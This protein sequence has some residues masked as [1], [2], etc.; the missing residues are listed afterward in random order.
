MTSDINSQFPTN[1]ESLFLYSIC[2]LFCLGS[3]ALLPFLKTDVSVHSSALVRPASEIN[4]LR[5]LS[6][7]RIKESHVFENKKV[8]EGEV[9]YIIESETLAEQ[10]KYNL[11]KIN[12]NVSFIR[13]VRNLIGTVNEDASHLAVSVS[14]ELYKQGYSA[15][16]QKLSEAQSR[17]TKAKKDYDR[18][19]KL[20]TERVIASAEFE[21]YQFELQ[22]AVEAI[23]QVKESQLSQW[24][25][26]LKNLLDEKHELESQLVRIGKE[27]ETLTIKSPLS[28]TLQNLAGVYPGSLVFAN[29][30]LGQISPDTSLVVI[31][32]VHPNDIG[33]LQKSMN[34]RL[35]VD[36]FNY[37][38]WGV[39]TGQVIDVPQ[40]IKII[41]NKPIFE[42]RCSLDK[43]FLQLKNGYKGYLKKGM[44]LQARFIVTERTL[45][46]LLY[47]KADDWLNPNTFQERNSAVLKQN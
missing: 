3:L 10:E 24:Q 16:L 2:L 25:N 31:A 23:N 26:E 11:E 35:Q 33:L 28:G 1:S 19:Q 45:W 41:D 34:V 20:Y 13:D 40:D 12:L 38:Q 29:Q 15:Y 6:S 8:N 47:D 14:N 30:E 21:N 27:K 17:F 39:A 37:N 42:V 32:F 5:S 4:T 43:D 36:A 9:L 18:Q 7:G 46:Q 22:K 44:T